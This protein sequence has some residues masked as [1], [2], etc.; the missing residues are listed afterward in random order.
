M[1]ELQVQ[2]KVAK[3]QVYVIEDLKRPL[4]ARKPAELLKLI[5]RLES[6]SSDDYKSKVADKYP[7]LFEGLGVMKDSYCITL[8]EDATPFQVSVPRKVPFPL[9]QKTKEELY[10]MLGTGS[11]SRVDQPTELYA[12]QV[13][14]RRFMES[15]SFIEWTAS[16]I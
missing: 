14:Y 9:Y 8:K 3:E 13:K 4:L 12:G 1:A 5:S 7:K 15:S 11:I 6:L 2:D 16:R 10:R